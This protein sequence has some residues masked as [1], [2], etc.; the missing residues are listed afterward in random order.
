LEKQHIAKLDD[1]NLPHRGSGK[2][3]STHRTD[4]MRRRWIATR[5][6]ELTEPLRHAAT[7]PMVIAAD[8]NQWQ[9][10]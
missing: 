3:P 8:G 2:Y 6:L 9:G 1:S 4:C 7:Q 5:G 10:R